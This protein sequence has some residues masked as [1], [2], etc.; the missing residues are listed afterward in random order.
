[1]YNAY[2]AQQTIPRAEALNAF[3]RGVYG[4]MGAGLGLTALVAV[5]VASSPALLKIVFNPVMLIA[6]VIAEFALVMILSAR[7]NRMAAGT[8]T[9]MFLA[10]SA[11]NGMTLSSI[12]IVYTATSIASAFAVTAGMFIAMSVYG[13]VTKRDL[14][15]LGSFL[16]MGLIG[17]V[18][19]MVVNIFLKSSMM[20]FIIDCVGVLVFTG[21][22]AYDTQ[23]LK[24]MGETA[25]MNDS[26]AIRR[27]SILGAL[28]LYL[29]FI[30]LFLIMLRLFGGNRD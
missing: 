18:I 1:M 29:D 19:A 26:T 23:R 10:Y 15:S 27:G 5:S 8:A 3:M 14:T 2:N 30:N 13:M 25:P 9:G 20:S 24:D 7:I 22:T 28:T 6:L 17:M 12:F 21:L 16:F 4:W 11:L